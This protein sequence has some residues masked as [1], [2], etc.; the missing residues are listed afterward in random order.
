MRDGDVLIGWGMATA[1]YP[2]NRRDSERTCRLR[3]RRRWS[4]CSRG[5]QDLGTGTYTIM[6]QIAADALNMPMHRVRVELGDSP[7]PKAP[8]SG[9][10]QTAAS[11]GAGAARRGR[12]REDSSCS[13]WRSPPSGRR[14][15]R[16]R[17]DLVLRRWFVFATLG[18]HRRASV[19]PALLARNGCERLVSSRRRQARRREERVLQCIPSARSSPRCGSTPIWRRSASAAGSA[20]SPPAASQRQ[21]RAQPGDRRHHLGHRHG[22]DGGD[23]ARARLGPGHQRQP[24][25]ISRAGERRHSRDRRRS[26]SRSRTG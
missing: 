22:A 7:F 20:R 18:P 21:D 10:S 9:G 19:L 14:C 15:R 6:A 8:I 13:R 17:R 5:S 1:T 11:V 24:G 4:T 3:P 12:G 2:A 16:R 26:S 25:R 23:A